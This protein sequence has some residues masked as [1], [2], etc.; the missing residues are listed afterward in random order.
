MN[1]LKKSGLINPSS[2]TAHIQHQPTTTKAS[3]H[4]ALDHALKSHKL[5]EQ[6]KKEELFC[7]MKLSE[8]RTMVQER[9]QLRQ[10]L[11]KIHQHI[12]K[13]ITLD[14][15][16]IQNAKQLLE[17]D[18]YP[19]LPIGD[20][21]LYVNNA[22]SDLDVQISDATLQHHIQSKVHRLYRKKKWKHRQKTKLHHKKL[23]D[24]ATDT[25]K[26]DQLESD[27]TSQTTT[28]YQNI[29]SKS[30]SRSTIDRKCNDLK[31]QC[32]DVKNKLKVIENLLELSNSRPLQDESCNNT[33]TGS[34]S[35]KK[36]QP[37][38]DSTEKRIK[39][40]HQI[41]T[42]ARQF[43]F[44]ASQSSYAQPTRSA[45]KSTLKKKTNSQFFGQAQL[46]FKNLIHIRSQW[47]ACIQHIPESYKA[48][49]IPLG[50]IKPSPPS[51]SDWAATLA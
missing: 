28:L 42:L 45:F 37:I 9:D 40:L 41:L 38:K 8:Y 26:S 18:R 31:K 15:L 30:I 33:K 39:Q 13:S 51:S 20:L 35:T 10:D 32:D 4:T 34:A 49:P 3:A 22:L 21:A 48:S 6:Y 27:S 36:L 25:F 12:Q 16:S 1:S 23:N 47:D 14:Q 44:T 19:N 46:S 7:R 50:W 5:Q 2:V 29:N 17:L 43:I 11:D 24:K